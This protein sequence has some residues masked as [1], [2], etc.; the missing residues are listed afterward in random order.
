MLRHPVERRCPRTNHLDTTTIWKK[1]I[2]DLDEGRIR[3]RA[4]S[5]NRNRLVPVTSPEDAEFDL[6]TAEGLANA[7]THLEEHCSEKKLDVMEQDIH[8]E[9]V[10]FSRILK[11][12]FRTYAWKSAANGGAEGEDFFDELRKLY[13]TPRSNIVTALGAGLATISLDHVWPL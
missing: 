8:A 10:A 4:A 1:F 13:P 11:Y 2:K 6:G 12:A 3:L 7:A 9:W 5:G